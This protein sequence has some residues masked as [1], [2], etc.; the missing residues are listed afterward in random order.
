[1]KKV[2]GIDLGATN[3]RVGVINEK[4][5]ILDVIREETTHQGSTE[6]IKQIIR[7]I[8]QIKGIYEI[9]AIAIGV[10]GRVK[11]DGFIFELPNLHVANIPLKDEIENF[12]HIRT[13]VAND[14]EV[15]GLAEAK[16]GRGKDYQNT[17]F[18]TIS[19]G[20]GGAFYRSC[21]AQYVIPEIGHTLFKVKDQLYEL[22]RVAS[23]YGI[24][25]LA[26]I[27]GVTIEQG[28]E[29]FLGYKSGDPTLSMIY[30]VWL[31]LISD[32][33]AF[34][35]E[36]LSPD[37]F[38][39]S[40]GVMKSSEIFLPDLIKK[41]PHLNIVRAYFDQDAGLLGAGCLALL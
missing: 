32:L 30:S 4:L 15:A 17:Y 21:H 16:A 13:I 23:G 41:N 8:E 31:D 5:E 26:Q 28:H 20:I 1:M 9:D 27:Y 22:E 10:P 11:W 12:F 37:I 39:L 2:I 38:V 18:L 6:L 3:I 35:N 29:L 36:T 40:G 24:I 33:L 7:L 19:S 14:A 25:A 34:V